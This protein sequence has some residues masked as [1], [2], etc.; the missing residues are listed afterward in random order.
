MSEDAT[1]ESLNGEVRLLRTQLRRLSSPEKLMP[2]KE[3]L[4]DARN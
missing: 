1:R 3:K 2:T 4:I